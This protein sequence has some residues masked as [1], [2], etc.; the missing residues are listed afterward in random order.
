MRAFA[1]KMKADEIVYPDPEPHLMVRVNDKIL[2]FEWM[3]IPV[4]KYE[5]PYELRER[6]QKLY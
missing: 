4:S 2:G 5:N 6:I 3:E 1:R